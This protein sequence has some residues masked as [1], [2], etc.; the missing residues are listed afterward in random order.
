MDSAGV[1][2][3]EKQRGEVEVVSAE[4]R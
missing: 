2:I 4:R 1:R 3:A